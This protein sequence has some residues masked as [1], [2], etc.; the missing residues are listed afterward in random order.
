MH[1]LWIKYKLNSDKYK[2]F[3][4]C[5]LNFVKKLQIVLINLNVNCN[6]FSSDYSYRTISNIDK[7]KLT[8]IIKMD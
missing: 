6:P 5:D 1:F 4:N 3:N 2:F 8:T 7:Q